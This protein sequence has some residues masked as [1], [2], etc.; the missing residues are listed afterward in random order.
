[1]LNIE[2]NADRLDALVGEFLDVRAGARSLAPFLR[3]TAIDEVAPVALH[4]LD[5]SDQM[6]IVVPNDLPW[7]RPTR[8]FGGSSQTSSPTR[9]A[10]AELGFGPA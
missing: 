4:G 1:M 6:L 7:S 10:L 9:C 2:Q 5:D 3:A 8:L